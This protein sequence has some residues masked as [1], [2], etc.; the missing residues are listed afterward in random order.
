[1]LLIEWSEAVKKKKNHCP[2]QRSHRNSSAKFGHAPTTVQIHAS[3][4]PLPDSLPLIS[5]IILYIWCQKPLRYPATT[6]PLRYLLKQRA[7]CSPQGT[8]PSSKT[9]WIPPVADAQSSEAKAAK[10]HHKDTPCFSNTWAQHVLI[11]QVWYSCYVNTNVHNP[12]IPN[13][14]TP[15]TVQT[16]GNFAYLLTQELFQERTHFALLL[17]HFSDLMKN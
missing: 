3:L 4:V 1:M 10:C 13:E 12:L 15:V 2:L 5:V 16:P 8:P 7:I 6:R 11:S 14:K 17:F 9:A